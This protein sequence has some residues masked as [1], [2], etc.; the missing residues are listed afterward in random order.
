MKKLGL[1]LIVGGLGYTAYRFYNASKVGVAPDAEWKIFA[2]SG[3]VPCGAAI[4]LGSW[5]Y[6]K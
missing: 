4:A 5:L 3:A 2:T 1:A 6:F